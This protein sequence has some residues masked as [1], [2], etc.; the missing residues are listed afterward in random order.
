MEAE[1]KLPQ[2]SSDEG[3]GTSPRL[4]AADTGAATALDI[5]QILLP[6]H[7]HMCTAPGTQPCQRSSEG[8]TW[9]NLLIPPGSSQCVCP[10]LISSPRQFG[11]RKQRR[12]KFY[13]LSVRDSRGNGLWAGLAERRHSWKM[14][15][16]RKQEPTVSLPI[17]FCSGSCL[18]SGRLSSM[19]LAAP[20][21]GRCGSSLP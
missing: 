10:S 18:G 13:R 20:G 4:R 11:S 15:G 8:P 1:C 17:T 5:V 21:Q 3:G 12:A 2:S 19:T 7:R 6:Y 14:K 9:Q 16:W